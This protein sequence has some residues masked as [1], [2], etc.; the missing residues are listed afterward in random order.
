M[1]HEFKLHA[2]AVL[3]TLLVFECFAVPIFSLFLYA[4]VARN[5]GWEGAILAAMLCIGIFVWWRAF[6]VEIDGL[7][8]RYRAPFKE[9]KVIALR[10]IRRAVKSTEVVSEGNRPP[11]RIEIYGTTNGR[12]VAFDI[13]VKPFARD[14]VYKME[15]LLGVV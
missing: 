14:D 5:V 9:T 10:D 4:A 1:I 12:E 6:S 8:L 2:R 15:Q 11:K 7:K 13:N 3:S